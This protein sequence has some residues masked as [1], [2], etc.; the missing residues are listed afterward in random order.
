MSLYSC[1]VCGYALDPKAAGVWHQVTCW[2]AVGKTGNIKKVEKMFRYA[3]GVCVTSPP[4]GQDETLF[5]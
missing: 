3:H 5:G 2:V 1:V 4:S